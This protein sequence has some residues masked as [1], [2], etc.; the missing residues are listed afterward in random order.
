[1]R[2]KGGARRKNRGGNEKMAK[3]GNNTSVYLL[4]FLGVKTEQDRRDVSLREREGEEIE[5]GGF[6]KCRSYC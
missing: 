6:K 3:E 5:E 4:K 2:M 1:L